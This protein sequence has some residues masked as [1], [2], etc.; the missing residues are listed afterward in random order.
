LLA[1]RGQKAEARQEF[2][3]AARLAQTIEPEYRRHWLGLIQQ[4]AAGL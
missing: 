3:S 2:R 4:E 1:A